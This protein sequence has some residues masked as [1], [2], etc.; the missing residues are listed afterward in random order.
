M[1]EAETAAA[2][3]GGTTEE[4]DLNISENGLSKSCANS[5]IPFKKDNGAIVRLPKFGVLWAEKPV[6]DGKSCG[7]PSIVCLWKFMSPYKELHVSCIRYFFAGAFCTQEET[8][9]L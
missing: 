5:D 4:F 2:A 7:I 9:D 1:T 6:G 3:A 8:C